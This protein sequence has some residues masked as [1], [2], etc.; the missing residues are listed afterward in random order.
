MNM[1]ETKEMSPYKQ[2]LKSRIL[3]T[4]MRL[5]RRNGIRAVRMDDVA[6]E[7]GISKR[8]LYE[9]FDNKELLL[10]EVVKVYSQQRREQINLRMIQCKNVM[11]ILLA[12]YSMK[13]EDFRNT[14][15]LFYLD[16]LKYPKV[17]KLLEKDNQRMKKHTEEFFQ[18]GIKE[19]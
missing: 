3:D 11:E 12:D 15:P 2:G 5:F 4:A 6:S 8:T 10:S 14:N 9:I 19:G 13:A 16:L 17:A 18:R 7:L 1:Q